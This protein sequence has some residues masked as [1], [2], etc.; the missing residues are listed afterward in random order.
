MSIKNCQ[1][2]RDLPAYPVHV[3]LGCESMASVELLNPGR[4]TR[5]I[6]LR[7][8]SSIST[9]STMKLGRYGTELD[10]SQFGAQ[11][12]ETVVTERLVQLK[13]GRV[14]LVLS[15]LGTMAIWP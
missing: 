2:I 7:K 5:S 9:K 14:A 10:E 13:Q 3:C 4:K 12:E 1:E 6:M 11:K 15:V 8:R